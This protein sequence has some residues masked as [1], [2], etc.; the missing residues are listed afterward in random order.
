LGT[1]A[2]GFGNN[3]A[4]FLLGKI[5]PSELVGV[6]FFA[7]QLVVQ[8]GTLLADNVY[9]VLVPS[10]ARMRDD[11][12]RIRAAT[13]RA[14]SV[15]VLF[16]S[17]ASMSI[18]A[19]YVPLERTLWQGKWSTAATA[20][21]ILAGVWPAAAAVSVLRA[22]QMAT[23]EFRQWGALTM[24]G[25]MASVGGT[26]IGAFI[27]RSPGSAAAG[28]AGGALLGAA[29]SATVALSR[30]DLAPAKA[31]AS[32]ARPW[33]VLAVAAT[34]SRLAGR[35]TPG[36]WFEIFLTV[37]IFL[38]L[39]IIGLRL[40]ARDSLEAFLA[41]LQHALRTTFASFAVRKEPAAS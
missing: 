2:I 27:G 20:V 38:C 3:G 13:L 26:V 12:V 6:Y 30:I 14:L 1:F 35:L 10:F 16:G 9:Q 21:Y 31:I 4:Y 28:F 23:G 15:V 40:L 36:S 32:L 11:L 18:A 8:L 37:P 19:I 25:A 17:A 41:F 5:L 34:V 24:F 22:L 7:Y 33:V 39:G 29:L